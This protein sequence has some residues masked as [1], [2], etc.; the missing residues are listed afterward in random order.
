MFKLGRSLSQESQDQVVEVIVRHL[1][2]FVWSA[3][4]M[5]DI[6]S[7]SCVT[8]SPWTP[9]SNLFTREGEN[10]MKKA[11]GRAR[12]DEEAVEGWPH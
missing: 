6:D 9:R 10:S 3:S 5:P 11:S 2:A 8:V 12:R 1:E 4:D 7:T